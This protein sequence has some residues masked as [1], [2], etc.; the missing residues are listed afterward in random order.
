MGMVVD[1]KFSHGETVY[2]RTDKEQQP[3]IIF[4]IKVFKSDI[5]YEVALGT[6]VS[7]HYDFELSPEPNVIMQTTG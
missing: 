1:N 4:C 7:A 6:T 3:R 2:L 5:L